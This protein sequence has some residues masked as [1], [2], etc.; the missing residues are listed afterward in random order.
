MLLAAE[1]ND[2]LVDRVLT[3]GRV[4]SICRLLLDLTLITGNFPFRYF[5]R[6]DRLHL[7]S[8]HER[9]VADA[10]LDLLLL[11]LDHLFTFYLVD[12]DLL[13]FL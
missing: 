2:I 6:H 11:L 13:P 1:Q 4:N 10:F 7:L 8:H 12:I 5:W 9:A 3:V